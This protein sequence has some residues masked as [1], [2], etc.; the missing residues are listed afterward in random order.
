M[1]RGLTMADPYAAIA[2]ADESVQV[3]LAEVLDLR[4]SD[5]QQRAMLHD[6]LSALE[7][8]SPARALD[9][10]CG[11]GS[12][13]RELLEVP[14]VTEVVGIDPS[15]VFIERARAVV[16]ERLSFVTGDGRELPFDDGSFDL[17][18]CH[19]V[20][21]HVPAPERVLSEAARV[22]RD[23][24]W[25]AV[26]DGDYPTA[27]VAN[28]AGDPLQSC[29]DAMVVSFVHDAFLTRRLAR[30]VHAAGWRVARTTSH[31]FV[32]TAEAEYMLTLVDRG[33]DV[34]VANG[35][36]GEPAAEALKAEAVGR[37]ERG[38]FFGHIAYLSVIARL[39]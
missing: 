11:T 34:L 24:A 32:E 31:G 39:A 12:V 9:V 35:R 23:E 13:T 6:Y 5:P 36:L 14:G 22:A 38:E 3:R 4:A 29:I 20:L 2:E 1:S 19:T 33:A 30:L 21:C 10:G 37:V 25:L 26:F 17:V 15:P 27:T 8:G 18:V 28:S 16:D 7:L